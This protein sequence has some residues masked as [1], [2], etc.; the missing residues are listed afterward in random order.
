M[1]WIYEW[2]VIFF[3]SFNGL[4]YSYSVLKGLNTRHSVELN[5][6]KVNNDFLTNI[7]WRQ[8]ILMFFCENVCLLKYLAGL[9]ETNKCLL[10]KRKVTIDDLS[11]RHVEYV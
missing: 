6:S 5:S 7:F 1:L 8:S 3:L 4:K 11:I 9:N 2:P 10:D